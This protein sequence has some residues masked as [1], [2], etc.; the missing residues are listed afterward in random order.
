MEKMNQRI[1]E[2]HDMEDVAEFVNAAGK[3]EFDVN[4]IS[5]NLYWPSAAAHNCRCRNNL[6]EA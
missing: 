2:F 4:V 5:G 3:S 1:V 6:P